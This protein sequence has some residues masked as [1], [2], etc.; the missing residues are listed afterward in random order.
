MKIYYTYLISFLLLFSTGTVWSQNSEETV[1]QCG[2]TEM[3]ERYIKNHPEEEAE[4]KA[5]GVSNNAN[6][7][8]FLK[9]FINIS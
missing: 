1:S 2:T 3:L 5:S 9:R 8:I 4:I 7:A 6:T